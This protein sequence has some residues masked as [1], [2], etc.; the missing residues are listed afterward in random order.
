MT[1]L[2]ASIAAFVLMLLG[3]FAA[4][5]LRRVLSDQHFTEDAKDIVRL[6]ASLMATLAALVLSLLISSANSAYDAQ[7]RELREIVANAVLLDSLLEEFGPQARPQRVK[8]REMADSLADSIWRHPGQEQVRERGFVSGDQALR[9][10]QLLRA[11][12]ATDD[13]QRE[14]RSQA[15]QMSLAGAQVRYVLYESHHNDFPV[16][17]LVILIGWLAALFMSFCLFTPPNR[18]AIAALV[19]LA[20]STSSA[21][22]MLLELSNPFDGLLSLPKSTIAGALAPLPP[23]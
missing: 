14:L 22:F 18:I 3:A 12:P 20:L 19:I 8:L 17:F 23:G 5:Q 21:L 10:H 13:R 1:P 6:S 4:V 16:P 15:L 9:F 11:L 2:F 7:R